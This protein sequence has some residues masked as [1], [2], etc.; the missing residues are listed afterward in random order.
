M[1]TDTDDAFIEKVIQRAM[2]SRQES[3]TPKPRVAALLV[4]DGMELGMAFRGE[5]GPGDHA[6]YG[7]LERKLAYDNVVGGTL[8]TTLEPCTARGLGKVPCADRICARNLGRVV[9]GML[10]PNQ[11]ICGRGVR[12]LRSKG[13]D[14]DLFPSH[15]MATV[16]DQNRDF[17]YYQDKVRPLLKISDE[18]LTLMNPRFSEDSARFDGHFKLNSIASNETIFIIAGETIVSD[19]LDRLTCGILRDA[20]DREG[21]GHE[22]RRSIIVSGASW[23]RD[24]WFTDKCPAISIGSEGA[25]NI[26]KEW[27]GIAKEKAVAAFPLG[28]GHGLY[29]SEP[30]PRAILY[31][32]RA[33][34]TR[35]AVEKYIESR[36]GLAEFLRNS[37]K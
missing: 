23:T 2:L 11:D 28:S 30:R 33:S 31:G 14:V 21:E 35:S 4:K 37:W 7:L 34:D 36:R 18:Q 3:Q 32:N 10:D 1:T 20:I 12:Q 17:I 19:L 13:I 9:V 15:Y 26:S 22:F 27:L 8:Y 29:L 5:T 6:E 25:N 16:E 24:R